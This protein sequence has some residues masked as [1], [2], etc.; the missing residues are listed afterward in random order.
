MLAAEGN[1]PALIKWLL[2]KGANPQAAMASG[3]HAIH[4]AVRLGHE[5]CVLMLLQEVCRI[6]V[7][8][9]GCPGKV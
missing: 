4:F 2:D 5:S 1:S 3:W 7:D 8:D 6:L 9:A